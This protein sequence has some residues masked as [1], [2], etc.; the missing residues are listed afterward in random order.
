[1]YE[2]AAELVAVVDGDTVDLKVD[3]GFHVYKVD[4]FRLLGINTPEH[5]QS[6]FQEAKDE[7][8]KWFADRSGK[9]IFIRTRKDKKEKYGRFLATVLEAD[10]AQSLNDLLVSK[11]LAKTYDGGP[12]T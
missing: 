8:A 10:A 9:Q 3:L 7:V 1:M 2:Y 6:G 12:R 5:G 11:G 4:R